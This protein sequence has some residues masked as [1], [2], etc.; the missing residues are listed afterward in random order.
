MTQ[1]QA[2]KERREAERMWEQMIKVKGGRERLHAITNMLLTSGDK[3]RDIGINLYVFPGKWWSWT[4]APPSPDT[5]WVDMTNLERNISIVVSNG[6][7][8]NPLEM[9]EQRRRDIRRE[10]LQEACAYLLETK[11]LQPKP[12]R[13]TQQRV[14]RERFDVVE[15]LVR[16]AESGLDER[17]DFY[18]E[19][20]S[21]LVYRVVRYYEGKPNR[22]Y[23]FADYVVTDSIQMPRRAGRQVYRPELWSKPF[24]CGLHSL[25][26][27]FNVDYDPRLFER[28]PSVAAGANAW[29]AARR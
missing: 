15:T 21:L 6:G 9:T 8:Y 24:F 23:C 20:E 7:A 26:A 18:V 1:T 11:W 22:Y 17:M 2:D 29:R 25:S 16:D 4:Q 27:R 19:P 28:P 5:I 3:P 12:L 13:V 10:M 14:G